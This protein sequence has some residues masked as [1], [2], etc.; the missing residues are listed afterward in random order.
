VSP[1]LGAVR[2]CGLCGNP[3]PAGALVEVHVGPAPRLPRADVVAWL[4]MACTVDVTAQGGG[5]R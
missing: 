4:C 3:T 2:V 1:G 5:R